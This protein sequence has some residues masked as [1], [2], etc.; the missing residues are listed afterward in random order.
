MFASKANADKFVVAFD[1]IY[2]ICTPLLI[3]ISLGILFDGNT[4]A[5]FL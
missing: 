4:I 2:F 1:D 3:I 5:V